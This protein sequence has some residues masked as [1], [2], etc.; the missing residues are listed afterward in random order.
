MPGGNESV[1]TRD[2]HNKGPYDIVGDHIQV[3]PQIFLEAAAPACTCQYLGCCSCMCTPGKPAA[4]AHARLF[5]LLPVH[6]LTP[7]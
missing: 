5:L 4:T 6:A 1:L 7:L 3:V 2:R